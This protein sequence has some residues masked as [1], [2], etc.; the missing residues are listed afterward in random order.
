MD[1]LSEALNRT[2]F[3]IT[4]QQ[5]ALAFIFLFTGYLARWIL[6]YLIRR[7][8]RIDL[9]GFVTF[10]TVVLDA[11]ETPIRWAAV[12]GG[13]W[14]ALTVLPI[15]KEP[16]D[17]DR[18]FNS[19][20]RAIFIIVTIWFAL[21]LLDRA[22]VVMK[23]RAEKTETQLDDQLVPLA[24][25]VIRIFIIVIGV[26]VIIQEMGYS[27]S[28]LIAGLGLGGAALA[29]GSRDL[30]ANLF[31]SISIFVDRPLHLGDIVQIGG[32]KG[33]VEEV[34]MRVT[35]IRDF[36]NSVTTLP[37]SMLTTTPVNNLSMRR[38]RRIKLTIGLTYDTSADRIEKAVEAIHR[39][40]RDDERIDQ[41]Q[42]L[43]KFTEFGAYSLDILVYCF[44]KSTE[45]EEHMQVRYELML[46]FMRALEEMGLEFAFPTRTLHLEGGISTQQR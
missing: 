18:F 7:A 5:Y 26:V 16:V 22:T 13:L 9:R 44:T 1:L 36:D 39:I 32:I 33:R 45:W 8:E 2:Y 35:R 24:R 27:P 37:N 10:R 19:S 28:S 41:E 17:L 30:M 21:R 38:K 14:A 12:L 46:Q 3:G 25:N 23:E 31:G 6:T 42:S 43:V 11:M 34:G 15:P 20:M 40:I 4:L 29:L